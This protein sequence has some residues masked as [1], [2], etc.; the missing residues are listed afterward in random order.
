MK[1][2]VLYIV[3]SLFGS[4]AVVAMPVA[5]ADDYKYEA[6]EQKKGEGKKD[7]PDRKD[8]A[9]PP[10]VRDKGKGGDDK[11]KDKPPKGKRPD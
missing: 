5:R 10:T 6:Y 9:G 2:L 4:T 1:K 7:R 3:I 8:P 11:P